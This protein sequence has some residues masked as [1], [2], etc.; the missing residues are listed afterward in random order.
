MKNW[1]Y[2]VSEAYKYWIVHIGI[3]PVLYSTEGLK[4][5]IQEII[6]RALLWVVLENGNCLCIYI[7]IQN[8][9]NLKGRKVDRLSLRT[10]STAIQENISNRSLLILTCPFLKRD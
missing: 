4:E 2:R 1:L 5:L 7:E 3:H 10:E 8:H 6:S 9:F